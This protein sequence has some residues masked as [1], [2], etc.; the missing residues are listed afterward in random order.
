MLNADVNTASLEKAFL[1]QQSAFSNIFL[2]GVLP[3]ALSFTLASAPV[4]QTSAQPRRV[5]VT[6]AAGRVG[7]YF[8]RHA[9]QTYDLRLM[10]RGD[11]KNLGELEGFGEIVRANLGDLPRLKEIC[12]GIDTVIHLAANP[13][14]SAVWNDVLHDN[15]IGT[16][17]LM[18][19]AKSQKV[20]RI[21]YASSVHAVA[22]YPPDVQIKTTEPVN[23]G[24]I[25]GVSKCFGE[26]MGRYLAEH[27]GVSVIALRIGAVQEPENAQKDGAIACADMFISYRDLVQIIEKSIEV[28]NMRWG[29]FN[30]VSDNRF[31]RLDITDAREL[32]G[33]EPQDNFM[34]LHPGFRPL[35]LSQRLDTAS[36]RDKGQSSG[37]REPKRNKE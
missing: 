19:A 8:S 25:Y 9:H 26:A 6:G 29:L 10:V 11:E 34:D 24:D 5:L 18:A 36:M 32:L 37:M 13:D 33:Y 17:N 28:P 3:V 31:K 16:Y 23:P 20:R 22:G 15:I 21:V 27:E 30:A 1:F 12:N 7:L 14:P 4:P 35:R 2:D